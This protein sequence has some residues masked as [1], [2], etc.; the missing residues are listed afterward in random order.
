M[1]KKATTEKAAF[2]VCKKDFIE[3]K[4]EKRNIK[5]TKKEIFSKLVEV[6]IENYEGDMDD[7]TSFTIEE[8]KL[9]GQYKVYIK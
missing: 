4:L 6:M 3:H 7:V 2:T 5:P 9:G 1:V 8:D